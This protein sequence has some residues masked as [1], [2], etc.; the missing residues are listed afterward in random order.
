MSNWKNVSVKKV[1]GGVCH[2]IRGNMFCGVH[3]EVL[4]LR[5]GEAAAAD[6]LSKP[7]TKPFDIT[8]R[9]KKGWVHG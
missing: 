2:L 5:L 1:F 3:K 7:Q 6:A 8:G 9:P 4:I